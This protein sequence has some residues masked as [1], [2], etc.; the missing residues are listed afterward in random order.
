[1]TIKLLGSSLLGLLF[2]AACSS[3]T[4]APSPNTGGNG[5]GEGNGDG[6]QT[7]RSGLT[8]VAPCTATVCGEIPPSS[9]A[10]KP[11]CR[12]ASGACGWTDPSTDG[13][14]SYRQCEETECGAKPDESVCPS[15]TT[16]KGAAC[17]SENDG[18]CLW[19]SACVPP[20]STTP[21]PDPDGCGPMPE[22]GVIC[23]DGSNG[24][25]ECMQ[26]GDKCEFQRTCD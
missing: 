17:G 8:F 19:R 14:V 12:E 22:I 4:P 5:G 20:R 23:T 16:F 11:E 18:A 10:S 9:K 13:S 3:T 21:C 1:M 15:G 6:T 25:L 2:I 24:A 7:T 26:R